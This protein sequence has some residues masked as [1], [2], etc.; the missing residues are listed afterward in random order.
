MVPSPCIPT[1]NDYQY[2]RVHTIGGVKKSTFSPANLGFS[3][4]HNDI[5]SILALA[6]HENDFNELIE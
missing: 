2:S 5:S 1:G 4:L 6:F 3:N